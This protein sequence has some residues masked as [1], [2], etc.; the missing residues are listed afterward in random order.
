MID[1][2]FILD[3]YG[4]EKCQY[5]WVRDNPKGT[6]QSVTVFEDDTIQMF[7]WFTGTE[8]ENKLY[9]T[10]L[11]GLENDTQFN[12]LLDVFDQYKFIDG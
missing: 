6:S 9:D 1:F 5:G 8:A 7:A 10:G 4:Y 12:V 3:S 11:I 2:A